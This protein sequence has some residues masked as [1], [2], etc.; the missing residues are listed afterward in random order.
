[1]LLLSEE[2]EGICLG[3][4]A[5]EFGVGALE[6][7]W[8]HELPNSQPM[9][10]QVSSLKILILYLKMIL[11]VPPASLNNTGPGVSFG[12]AASGR[13]LPSH[14]VVLGRGASPD[15]CGCCGHEH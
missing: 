6:A 13:W 4:S 9:Y 3:A 8:T 10:S 7:V 12:P 5:G 14:G 1:M 15:P 2:A 11:S